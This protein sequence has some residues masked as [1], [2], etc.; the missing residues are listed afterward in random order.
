MVDVYNIKK[1]SLNR[2]LILESKGVVPLGDIVDD[3]VDRPAGLSDDS[4]LTVAGAS[5]V[6][7][8]E[9]IL[10]KRCNAHIRSLGARGPR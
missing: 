2:E 3:T 7:G 6:S 4:E 5:P 8:V 9:S 1:S 10:R